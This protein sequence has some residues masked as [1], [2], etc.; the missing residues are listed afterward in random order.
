MGGR[1]A[2]H[3]AHGGT[4]G[5]NHRRSYIPEVE[6]A[7]EPRRSRDWL[8]Q[9][10]APGGREEDCRRVRLEGRQG[11]LVRRRGALLRLPRRQRGDRL[12]EVRRL[13]GDL[14]MGSLSP[15][16]VCRAL[17]PRGRRRR[18][19]LARASRR[20]CKD[21]KR[22]PRHH[23]KGLRP[24]CAR[25]GGHPEARLPRHEDAR[26]FLRAGYAVLPRRTEDRSRLWS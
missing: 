15:P 20:H 19:V 23:R 22:R 2:V 4:S 24:L 14:G 18:Q 25:L 21:A 26:R 13:P 1:A 6:V 17:E 5:G 9:R 12:L 8:R 3:H 7:Y 11:G 16:D 10:C